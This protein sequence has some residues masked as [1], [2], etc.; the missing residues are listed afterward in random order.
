MS[1]VHFVNVVFNKPQLKKSS[2]LK[3]QRVLQI[4]NLFD[5]SYIDVYEATIATEE[6]VHQ[7]PS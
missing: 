6:S 3:K 2:A 4:T 1:T 5:E 7:I